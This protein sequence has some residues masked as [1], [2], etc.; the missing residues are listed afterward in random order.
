MIMKK[1]YIISIIMIIILMFFDYLTKT[2]II[3]SFEVNDSMILIKD[4]LKFYY[5][6]NYGASFGML[7][8]Q[9]ILLVIFTVVAII[10]LFGEIKKSKSLLLIFSSSLIIGGAL[11]NLID[12][13][14]RG[15]VT[16]LRVE[17][18]FMALKPPT[19]QAQMADSAPPARM[20][21][22]LPRRIR[23][24]ASARALL[25]DAQAEVVV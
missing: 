5:I 14:F 8:G 13:V 2:L 17:R 20:A 6:K 24:K 25:D 22:A 3:N 23:L 15:Y 1:K 11:G 19:P 10:Y 16:S 4:F 7:S 18:A 12:R 21:S 9:T